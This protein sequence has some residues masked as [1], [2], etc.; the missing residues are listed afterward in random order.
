MLRMLTSTVMLSVEVMGVVAAAGWEGGRGGG[1]GEGR[2]GEQ[3][4]STST[5]HQL[6]LEHVTGVTSC[7]Q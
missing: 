3:E 5:R 4:G 6:Q 7:W 2:R 1:Q